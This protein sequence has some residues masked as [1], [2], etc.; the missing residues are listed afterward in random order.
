MKR[1]FFLVLV[2]SLGVQARPKTLLKRMGNDA[3]GGG[4]AVVCRNTK[5]K[6]TSAET[7]DLFEARVLDHLTVQDSSLDPYHRAIADSLKL[8]NLN[9]DK[10]RGLD[11]Y[12]VYVASVAEMLPPDIGLEPID[13]AF[14]IVNKKGCKIEQLARYLEGEKLL[15]DSEI[16][17]ALDKK[18]QAALYFHEG[19]YRVLR[20]WG[21]T[22][23]KRTRKILGLI[24][25]D[26][27]KSI[28]PVVSQENAL[29]HCYDTFSKGKIDFTL[30]QLTESTYLAYFSVL[31]SEP[32][33]TPATAILSSRL[34]EPNSN[35]T[36]LEATAESTFDGGPTFM[37]FHKQ[38]LGDPQQLIFDISYENAPGENRGTGIDPRVVCKKP[39]TGEFK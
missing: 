8:I 35:V 13:D 4:N 3:G 31:N 20:D 33:I 28:I 16:W 25:S 17:S 27:D 38:D 14:P 24:M 10:L 19:L 15:I 36:H 21:A 6:I 2:V 30:V 12:V 26:G 32:L 7:L 11:G 22:T 1:I 23:S 34:F 39:A 29:F 5:G 18:S 37:K 9:P